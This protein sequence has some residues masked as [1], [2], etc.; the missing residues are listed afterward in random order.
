MKMIYKILLSI[1]LTTSAFA[2]TL[3]PDGTYVEGDNYTL[4]PDGRYIGVHENDKEDTTE[5]YDYQQEADM[6]NYYEE[7]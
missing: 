5:P 1:S 4:T 2:Y 3:A 6:D 7:N